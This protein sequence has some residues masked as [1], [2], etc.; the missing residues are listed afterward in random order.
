ML[1]EL[2]RL[3]IE[4]SENKYKFMKDILPIRTHRTWKKSF[5]NKCVAEV[6]LDIKLYQG[7]NKK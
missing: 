7:G 4:D 2:E 1:E 3:V 6:I 5:L